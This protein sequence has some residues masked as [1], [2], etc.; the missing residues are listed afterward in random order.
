M[1][2][3]EHFSSSG[4]DSF[5]VR[6]NI[7]IKRYSVGLGMLDEADSQLAKEHIEHLVDR[8]VSQRPPCT[9]TMRWVDTLPDEVHDKLAAIGLVE[10]HRLVI[11][12]AV[13]WRS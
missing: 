8:H 3:L 5:R 11:C 7:G 6:F 10:P 12:R 1:A 4:R 13:C 9:K 2:F